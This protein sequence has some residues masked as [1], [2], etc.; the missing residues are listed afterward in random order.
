LNSRLH[1]GKASALPLEPHLTV[2]FGLD[3]LDMGV[4][5]TVFLGWPQITFLLI[6][7]FKE[8]R[9]TGV[10]HQYPACI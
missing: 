5:Q 10:R 6:S 8:A 3:I 9:I 1:T 2:C 4:S 7:A